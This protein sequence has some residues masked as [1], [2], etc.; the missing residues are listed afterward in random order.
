LR[1]LQDPLDHKGLLAPKGRQD[2]KESKV[3]L[4][5]LDRKVLKE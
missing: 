4:V 3:K 2:L 5:Q 1:V